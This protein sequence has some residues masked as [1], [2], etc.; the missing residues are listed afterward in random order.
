MIR[1]WHTL[2]DAQIGTA[3]RWA[4]GLTS[5]T[6]M[7]GTPTTDVNHRRPWIPLAAFYVLACTLSW[8][9]WLPLLL[10]QRGLLA[11]QPSQYWHLAG[12][13]GPA[14][15]A[16]VVAGLFGGTGALR[17]LLRRAV[18]WRVPAIWHVLAWVS[19]LV[20]FG[21]A[22]LALTA[23]GITWDLATFG[24]SLEY[25]QLPAAGYWLASIVCY[26]FGEELGWR[27]FALPRLQHG[28]S[29]LGATV[30]L[31][32]GWALWHL[33]L[34]GFA[35]G[36]SRMGG[37]E[38]VG[39]Y[40]SILTGAIL[41]TW[42]FNSTGGSVLIAAVFHGMMDVA[43]VSP[44]PAPL[45]AVVGALVTG[46]GLAVLI[47]A[48]PRD[49]SRCGKV[50]DVEATVLGRWAVAALALELF[51]AVGAIGG[52]LTLMAGPNGELMPLP[53]SALAGSPFATY[54]VPGAI[55]FAVLGLGP[56]GAAALSWRRHVVAPLL[57]CAAGGAL[58]I[59]IVVQI[60]IVGYSNDPPLQALYLGLGVVLT[61]VG[62]GWRRD[63]RRAARRTQESTNR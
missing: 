57:A 21:V 30:L 8:T 23:A 60:T 35:A 1:L 26:G 62:L 17:C 39:W 11:Y 19:P 22:A 49:L 42:L 20:V 46:W 24:R 27:G 43:F 34:F 61:L 15:A 48:G 16:A 33:P 37:P 14:V 7:P 38:I 53:V 58:M 51:L 45:S 54:F 52:G 47:V 36:L 2:A 3:R 12:S 55:L 29:A 6:T 63:A 40:F 25:P 44:A 4:R 28:R 10:W 5:S 18:A 59:W 41:F 9:G 56:L 32:L 13:L 50:V 31:S